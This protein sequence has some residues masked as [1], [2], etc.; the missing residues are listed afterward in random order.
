VAAAL[1]SAAVVARGQ[2]GNSEDKKALFEKA[3]AFVAAFNK[4]DAE[5]LAQFWTPEGLYRD[6]KDVD[7][8]GRKAI[9][10]R[11]RAFFAHNKGLKLRINVGTLRWVT[12]DVVIEEGTTEVLHP[13]GSPP[14]VA[15][16]TILHVKKDGEWYLDI[17]KDRVYVA[18]SNY[19]HLNKLEWIIGDWAA[20]APEGAEQN[21]G[22]M[23]FTWGPNQNF[24]VGTIAT[25][26]KN[27]NL[28]NATQWFGWDAKAKQVRS[29]MF[30]NSGSFSEGFWT[31]KGDQ[32]INKMRTV[33]SDGKIVTARNI[34]AVVDPDTITWQ[35]T[36]RTVDGKE[37][38]DT[39]AIKIK[40]VK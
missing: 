6:N 26:Y 20:E 7:T 36:E 30:D 17:V 24:I 13:D 16:Y 34:V 32:W 39:P 9:A 10:K 35:S 37:F 5:A 8:K 1:L 25:T 40:R 18:P 33:L 21:I 29:W 11:F 38:P 22:R 28:S 19:K 12:K 3:E 2:D 15:G 23:S 14:S 31:H 4:G 27:I